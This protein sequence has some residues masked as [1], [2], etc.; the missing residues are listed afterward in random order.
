MVTYVKYWRTNLVLLMKRIFSILALLV[1]PLMLLV[2][3]ANAIPPNSHALSQ[4]WACDAGYK[5]QEQQCNK[6]FIPPNSVLRGQG[7]VCKSGFKRVGQQCN[8]TSTA[9]DTQKIDLMKMIEGYDRRPSQQE[10]SGLFTREVVGGTLLIKLKRYSEAVVRL[11]PYANKGNHVAQAYL[12]LAYKGLNQPK[13]VISWFG[14]S[15]KQGNALGLYGYGMSFKEGVGTPQ[16]YKSAIFW[17]QKS[18][19]NGFVNAMLALGHMHYKGQGVLKSP[20]KALSYFRKAAAQN[21]KDAQ[22][23]IGLYYCGGLAVKEDMSQ[24]ASWMQKAHDNGNRK[25]ASIW[26]KY[27]LWKYQ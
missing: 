7:W 12:G 15:A 8:K 24:C 19:N 9:G 4:G 13:K 18:A 1:L 11:T 25:V 2:K 21:N 22:F 20:K 27:E 23:M 14:K 5:R 16:N 6:I 10:L 17:F 3:T 26:E